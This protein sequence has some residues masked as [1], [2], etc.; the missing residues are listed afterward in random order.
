MLSSRVDRQY[1]AGNFARLPGRRARAPPAPRC[2]GGNRRAPSRR[3]RCRPRAPRCPVHRSPG[4]AP[5][6]CP[7]PAPA[8]ASAAVMNPSHRRGQRRLGH[9]CLRLPARPPVVG[10]SSSRP[11]AGDALDQHRDLDRS[12]SIRRPNPRAR[13]ATR[14]RR[15][16]ATRC[17]PACRGAR[18]P[19]CFQSTRRLASKRRRA[20]S[21]TAALRI[22]PRQQGLQVAVV[23][24]RRR[25][26][27]GFV[28]QDPEAPPRR[29]QFAA[30][31]VGPLPL[32]TAVQQVP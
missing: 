18:T 30:R 3:S 26:G 17:R 13:T 27:D 11:V 7:R 32:D 21:V 5:R 12:L 28:L 9:V 24:R 16:P 15:P 14:R 29:H 22:Q 23:P 31:Y 8:G 25:R 19:A 20:S 6:P 1:T 10:R 4:S 2:R